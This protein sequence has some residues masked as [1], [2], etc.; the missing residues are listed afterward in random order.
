MILV[1]D[2]RTGEILAMAQDKRYDLNSF[3]TSNEESRRNLAVTHLFEPGSI[4]KVFTGLAA[5]DHKVV[6]PTDAF[7]GNDGIDVSGHVMHNADNI[8]YG[9]V[10]F[11]QIIEDSINTGMIR[12]AQQ[13]GE[14]RFHAFLQVLGF[15]EITGVKLPGE[16]PGILRPVA[17]WSG[18]A[19][20]A[21][22]IGQS[23]AVTGIQLI[24]A[25][26]VVAGDGTLPAPQI[27]TLDAVHDGVRAAVCSA[28]SCTTMR[29]L[30]RRVVE[31]GTG[32][33]AAIEDYTIAGKT[34]TA[35][36]AIPGRG[37]V[38]G[39]YTSLFAGMVPAAAPEIVCLVVLDEVGTVPVSGG[40][41]AGQIFRRATERILNDL[42][43][44]PG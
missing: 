33:L 15:G 36:K 31:T 14:E 11:A 23:V 6:N 1:M 10:A 35:Q 26:A 34:G 28:E 8:S 24:R 12:V 20:A 37:Y 29:S 5:L 43:I 25:L 9:T 21:T 19:L 2:P 38:S 4:F 41:T 40:Y 22:S 17:Q 18:L 32:T 30:M 44:P 27:T 39:L 3:W 16:E 42:R 13:L 7:D